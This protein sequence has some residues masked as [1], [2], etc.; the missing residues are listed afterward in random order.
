MADISTAEDERCPCISK[1]DSRAVER[2]LA[3]SAPFAVGG[4]DE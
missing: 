1:L 3:F 2:V 4:C